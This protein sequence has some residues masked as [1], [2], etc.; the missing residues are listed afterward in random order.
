MGCRPT[1]IKPRQPVDGSADRS[2]SGGG[3][4]TTADSSRVWVT[5]RQRLLIRPTWPRLVV[6]ES[7]YEGL[8]SQVFERIFSRHPELIRLFPFGATLENGVECRGCAWED[9]D[10]DGQ[11]EEL[12]EQD[13]VI[14]A[15]NNDG[16]CTQ[17]DRIMK[18]VREHPAFRRHAASFVSAIGMAVETM[19]DW[20]GQLTGTLIQLGANHTTTEG[21]TVDNFEA[22]AESLLYDWIYL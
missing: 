15:Y 22:F 3:G 21:F 4:A 18:L 9:G 7:D 14:I 2:N 19:D 12:R 13:D 6:H 17:N 5:R 10:L 11:S 8:G 20:D 1:T 16:N